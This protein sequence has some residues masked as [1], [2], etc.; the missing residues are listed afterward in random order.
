[1]STAF[2]E[3]RAQRADYL[4]GLLPPHV[5]ARDAEA[6][7]I[8]RAL[9]EAVAAELAVVEADLE[10]LYDSW[11]VETCPEWVVPYLADLVGLEG[12]PGDLGETGAGVSRRGVV[13]NTVAYRRRKG[14]A[15]VL[16]Q[17]VRDVTGWPARA[18]EFYRLLSATTHVNHARL[19]RPAWGSVRDAA[20]AELESSR[21]AGGS[22]SRFAH[23]GEVRAVSPS[24][25]GGQ[26]RYDI[27][28]VGVFVFP[29]QV[30]DAVQVPAR[31]VGDEWLVHPSGWDTPLCAAPD[32]EESIE[33]LA[34]ESD[35]TVPLRP[36]RLLAALVGARSGDPTRLPLAVSVDGAT[37]TP[38][39]IRVCGLEAPA[40]ASGG[41]LGGWQVMVDAVR[42]AL[43]TRNDGVVSRP[44]AVSVDYAY[45]ASAEV[46]AGS[47]DRTAGHADALAADPFVGDTDTG[48]GRVAS[49]VRVRAG[50]AAPGVAVSIAAGLAEVATGWADPANLGG[51][52]VVSVTDSTAYAGDLAASVPA[53]SRLVLVAAGWD[54]RVLLTGE[55]QAPVPGVYAPAGLMPR[56]GGGL[57]VDGAPGAGV[58]LDGLI[59]DGDVVVDPGSLAS[60]TISQCTIAGTVRVE[61]GAAGPNRDLVVT[62]LRSHLGGIVAAETV[63]DVRLADSVVDPALTGAP[64]GSAV[65]APSAG[66]TVEGCTLLGGLVARTLAMTSTVGVGVVTVLD[67]QSGCARFSYVAAGSRTPRRYRCVPG[68]GSAGDLPSFASIAP[69]SPFYAS[70]ASTTPDSVRRGGEFGA[71]MGVHHHLRRPARLDA[72]RRLVAPY[73]PAGQQIGM[74]GS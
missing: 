39:R 34:A 66:V 18:V 12:L 7:G 54:G 63:P 30:Y 38:D 42:G 15:A 4:A 59:V 11:F 19:D 73:L 1:M 55:V 49:Q 67:R 8:L 56:I 31:R 26:G 50:A 64:G 74:F 5:L 65:D 20:G 35:L 16:E 58:L 51:T 9:L 24:R 36:R 47:Y 46:G 32:T 48:S 71:E 10:T 29:L 69:G 21:L 3:R 22:L 45:A 53:E 2:D 40:T 72:A 17:V 37:L 62:V 6:G 57:H 25:L 61:A 14:T 27:P 28:H 13:A 60:L 68:P 70:L 44:A 23:T 41:P 43:T 52:Q 33:H